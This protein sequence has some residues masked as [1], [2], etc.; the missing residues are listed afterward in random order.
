MDLGFGRSIWKI[1]L[2]IANKIIR[3]IIRNDSFIRSDKAIWPMGIEDF[4]DKILYK[5]FSNGP[6]KNQYFRP[7]CFEYPYL[8]Q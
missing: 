8:N 6:M 3:K 7:N 2:W 1:I 4:L 5:D